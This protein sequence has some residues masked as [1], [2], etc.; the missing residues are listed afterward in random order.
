MFRFTTS[1]NVS[2]AYE[3]WGQE[4]GG[5]PVLL[6][7]GYGI[8]VQINWVIPGVVDALVAA[9]RHVVALHTRG[10]GESDKPH[11]S[12]FYGEERMALDMSELIDTLGVSQIDLVG[13]SMGSIVALIVASRE[14]RVRRLIVGGIGES[15]VILGGIDSRV[16]PF[17]AMAEAML[18]EDP[19][20]I[21]HPAVQGMRAFVD[22][23]GSDRLALAAQAR[24][25]HATPIALKSITAPTL[26]IVGNQD[27][28]AQRPEVL[29]DAIADAR[30]AIKSGDHTGVASDPT[31]TPTLV[32]FLCQN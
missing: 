17:E 32:D 10:H 31:F 5:P 29:V 23:C 2:I 15:A 12:R 25:F 4:N 3:Q 20:T 24:V 6:C 13:Y 22:M 30:L 19:A 9:G 1:D 11:D 8:N 21:Q 16:L 18:A 26:V 27:L 7:H 28:L 14:P